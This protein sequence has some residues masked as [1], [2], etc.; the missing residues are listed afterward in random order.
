LL[1]AIWRKDMQRFFYSLCIFSLAII[2][3]SCTEGDDLVGPREGDFGIYLA[4]NG[5][6]I[7]SDL[8]IQTYVLN[9]HKLILNDN[10]VQKM[11]SYVKWNTSFTPPIPQFGDLYQQDL[12]VRLKNEVIYTGKFSSSASSRIFEGVEI[13]DILMITMQDFL[14]IEY[15]RLRADRMD[16]PRNDTRIFRYFRIL[17]KFLE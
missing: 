12:Q 8:D 17:G 5:E 14:T 6:L 2:G 10:G 9:G 13:Y 16:D 3:F 15:H 4:K 11:R 7:I 1:T